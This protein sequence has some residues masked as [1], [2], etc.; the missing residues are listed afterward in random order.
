MEEKKAIET[1]QPIATEEKVKVLPDNED[2]EA[3]IKALEEDKTRLVG[4]K[5]NYKLA[6]LKEKSKKSSDDSE[7]ESDEDKIRRIAREEAINA[8]IAG[9]DYEKDALLQKALKENKELKLANLNKTSAP[10]AMGVHSEGESV[11]DT[12][13]SPEL[14]AYFKSRNFT[15]KDIERYKKNIARYGK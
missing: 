14:A 12:Q 4:E 15:E 10:S 11:K 3:R 9:I 7:E 1:A 2:Y 6:Y 13:I 5:E 8:K